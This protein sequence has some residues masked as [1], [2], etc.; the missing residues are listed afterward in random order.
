[1]LSIY[2]ELFILAQYG[3]KSKHSTK[4]K[5]PA[6]IIYTLYQYTCRTFYIS[7]S[8]NWLHW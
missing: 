1:M 7:G 2:P 6:S 8:S 4:P 3:N 5:I